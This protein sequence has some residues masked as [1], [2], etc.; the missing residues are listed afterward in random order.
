MRS[1]RIPARGGLTVSRD[2]VRAG[3]R[4]A[5]GGET[6]TVQHVTRYAAGGARLVFTTG[7]HLVLR[8]WTRLDVT[9]PVAPSAADR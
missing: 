5:I 7:E 3:D 1:G 6:F 4:V 9:R 2:T 8:P